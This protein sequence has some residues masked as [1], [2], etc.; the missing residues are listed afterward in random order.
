[1][2]AA[3]AAGVLS[4]EDAVQI[5]I[6]RGDVTQ[7][8]SGLGRMAVVAMSAEEAELVLVPY[9]DRVWVTAINSPSTIVLSG[10]PTALAEVVAIFTQNGVWNR[11]LGVEYPSH[12]P[13]MEPFQHELT[14]LV[15]GI[16][17]H[18]HK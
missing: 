8:A 12:S 15:D 14:H 9:K 4:L 16:T 6:N 13:L 18:P 5:V 10:E 3:Y 1:M 17:A 7:R 2:A 11:D